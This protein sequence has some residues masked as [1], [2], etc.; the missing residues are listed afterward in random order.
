MQVEYFASFKKKVSHEFNDWVFPHSLLS[1][2]ICSVFKTRPR[3][4]TKEFLDHNNL[5]CFPG[6][7]LW[8]DANRTCQKKEVLDRNQTTKKFRYSLKPHRGHWPL[9]CKEVFFLGFTDVLNSLEM[10]WKPHMWQKIML[11]LYGPTI[12]TLVNHLSVIKPYLR[13]HFGDIMQCF[14][15]ALYRFYFFFN[16]KMQ[17][18]KKQL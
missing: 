8:A 16:L 6:S 12:L 3:N 4:Q 14:C 13:E 9:E 15:S 7:S 5:I 17:K 10:L 18:E 11:V 1:S 2:V